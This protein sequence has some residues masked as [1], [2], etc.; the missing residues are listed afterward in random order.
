MEIVKAD[1]DQLVVAVEAAMDRHCA[2]PRS[3]PNPDMPAVGT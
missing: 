2:G 3:A 1:K